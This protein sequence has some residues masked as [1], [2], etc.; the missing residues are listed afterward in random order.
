V[1]RLQL[2]DHDR[3]DDR[4]HAVTE[5]KEPVLLHYLTVGP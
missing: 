5:C 4:D 2:Q 1:R 3:D